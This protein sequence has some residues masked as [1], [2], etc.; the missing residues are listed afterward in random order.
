MT[1]PFHCSIQF[2]ELSPV[3][4]QDWQVLSAEKGG[5]EEGGEDGCGKSKEGNGTVRER[6]EEER[7]SHQL[8]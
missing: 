7:N 4:L 8:L 3:L 6:Q 1:Y 2:S 5:G